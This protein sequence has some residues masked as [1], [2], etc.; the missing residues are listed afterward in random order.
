[1]PSVLLF[2]WI[3]LAACLS[4]RA[5]IITVGPSGDHPSIGAAVAAAMPG[6]S[7]VISSGSFVE[8]LVIDKPLEILGANHGI[9]AGPA[10]GVRGPE[11]RLS[12]G[13]Q[14]GAGA[15]G[16]TV[17]GLRIEHGFPDEGART[18]LRIDASSVTVRDCIIA[19]VG[20]VP[21]PVAG[22]QAL[23][24]TS[25]GEGLVIENCWFD[26][27]VRGVRIEGAADVLIEGNRVQ[28]STVSGVSAM[29]GSPVIVMRANQ[30]M[31]NSL[32]VENGSASVIDA[33]RNF[34]NTGVNP[35]AA[36]LS[37]GYSGSVSFSPWYAEAAMLTLVHGIRGDVT[38]AEGESL[39][40]DLLTVEPG[41]TLR[42]EKG[43]V[44]A[45]RLDLQGGGVVEV[46]DGDLELGVPNGGTHVIS[47]TFRIVHSLGSIEILGDTTFSGDTLALVSDFHIA[48]GVSLL[49]T[50][51]LVMDGCNLHGEDDFDIVL[52]V[53]ATLEM[54]RCEVRGASLFVVGSDLRLVDNL[55]HESTGFIF[56]T[57]QG[58]EVYHNVFHGGL[59]QFTILPGATVSTD[60]EG[61]GNVTSVAEARN[62]LVL[63]WKASALPDR[64][65]DGT[66]GTLY[67][68]PGDPV[69]VEIDSGGFT[70]R[71]QAAEMLLAYHS[72]YLDLTGFHPRAPWDNPLHLLDQ[73]LSYF[74]KV[75]M[76]AG[77]GFAHEDPDGTL[78]D[79]VIG[80]LGF[81]A[82]PAEGKTLVFFREKDGTDAA[83][84]DTRLTRST[85]GLPGYLNFPFTRNSG[86]LV[87]DGTSPVVDEPNA[88]VSQDAGSGPVDLRLAGTYTREG[89]VDISFSVH[90]ALA[91]IDE[92]DATVV[93][94][95]PALLSASLAGVSEVMV[96]DQLHLSY[97]FALTV[98]GST[99]DGVYD[100]VVTVLDRS[101]NPAEVV[102][103]TI[104]IAKRIATVSVAS[105]GLVADP[106]ER[107]VVFVMTDPAG[108]VLQTRAVTLEFNGGTASTVLVGL[109]AGTVRISAKT[110]WT[111]RRRLPC[112]FNP[113]GDATVDFTG[114][115]QLPGGD[116]NGD[117]IINLVDYNL[118]NANWFTTSPVADVSGNGVVNVP[119]FNILN[120]NWFTVGDPP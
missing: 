26:G 78:G 80:E 6:D 15:D 93:L 84:I 101:G 68:Q 8:S 89:T 7:I 48:D 13:I 46:I 25:D 97:D 69:R 63:Q 85:A 118:L 18:G 45:G 94:D 81:D 103:G 99:P 38:V 116:L 3:L 54:V 40:A 113:S 86:Q 70:G 2:A 11:T 108:V 23:R 92:P 37:N 56:S 91:G 30:L 55:F 75:D 114:T 1:M 73:P 17:S 34:W 88:L 35:P 47:G 120:S 36:D 19:A 62:R 32:A 112:I 107:E 64:T 67:V 83:G 24:A 20:V 115:S 96:G 12:G 4:C 95:G 21:S 9:S 16:T 22:S 60:V 100:V 44:S 57:V 52:N 105:Q 42:V 65:L 29:P 58:A 110:A 104:E 59:G 28:N 119:D 106:I 90:D 77:F 14:V 111:Q 39:T 109:P 27:N 82:G 5:A 53:G 33:R 79:H 43:R 87:I 117:N 98:D 66:D 74:G 10:A 76:A 41:A 31:G 50:G 71:V 61:W 72:G 102:L 51:S 49:I